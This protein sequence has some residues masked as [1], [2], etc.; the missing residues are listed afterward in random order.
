MFRV[1]RIT[2]K[3]ISRSSGFLTSRVCHP[4]PI[5]FTRRL[6]HSSS[7]DGLLERGNHSLLNNDYAQAIQHY[8]ASSVKSTNLYNNLG[9]C[10]THLKQHDLAKA[11]YS[12]A[13]AVD[14]TCFE[15]TYNLGCLHY[16]LKD[17][18]EALR[19]FKLAHEMNQEHAFAKKQYLATCHTLILQH[20][21]NQA[22]DAAHERLSELVK[23]DEYYEYGMLEKSKLFMKQGKYQEARDLLIALIKFNPHY[24]AAQACYLQAYCELKGF[25]FKDAINHHNTLHPVDPIRDT[26]KFEL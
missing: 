20:I 15:A 14:P 11:A 19:Y 26:S 21:K 10:Y 2:T 18:E 24:E 23:H 7:T 4:S 8:S 16:S 13:L 3:K 25:R 22:Y 12:N 17:L 1:A 6:T 9:L 5:R